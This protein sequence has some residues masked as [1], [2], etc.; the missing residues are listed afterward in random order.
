M[1]DIVIS[2]LAAA[3][4][5]TVMVI[6]SIKCSPSLSEAPSAS[7]TDI[8]GF[9]AETLEPSEAERN[10]LP[11][12]TILDKRRYVDAVGNWYV[13]SLVVG[14]RS[15]SSIHRPELCLP[16]QGFQ[17]MSPRQVEAAGTDWQVVT[18]MRRAQSPLGFAY[19]FFNQDGFRTSS[20]VRRIMQ[21]VWDRSIHSRI[22]RW[23]MVTVVS[24]VAKDIRICAFLAKL[25]EVMR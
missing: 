2:A 12:D 18:L 3:V 17:M 7:L 19:T 15:K 16:S 21:D 8:D 5:V 24:S 20:H 10:V 13:V 6:Q 11:S 14:G 4:V 1:R 25:R 22:D 23:A 9:T